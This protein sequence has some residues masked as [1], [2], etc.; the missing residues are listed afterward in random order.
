MNDH[1]F[2]IEHFP[3][4]MGEQALHGWCAV[5]TTHKTFLDKTSTSVVALFSNVRDAEAYIKYRMDLINARIG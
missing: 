5:R 2:E 4:P 3:E 1:R